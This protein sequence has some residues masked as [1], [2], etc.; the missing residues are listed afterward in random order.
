[1]GVVFVDP[2]PSPFERLADEYHKLPD[3]LQAGEVTQA[4]ID[5]K[6]LHVVS[7]MMAFSAAALFPPCPLRACREDLPRLQ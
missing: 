6:V 1:L 7:A 3:M 2:E 4:D 5:E